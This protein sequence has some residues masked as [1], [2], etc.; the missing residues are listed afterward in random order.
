LLHSG[1]KPEE[2][3]KTIRAKANF[4]ADKHELLF[5]QF[6]INYNNEAEQFKKG[7]VLFKEFVERHEFDSGDSC[8]NQTEKCLHKQQQL[9]KPDENRKRK[10]VLCLHID[11]IGDKFWEEHC[12][13]LV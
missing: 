5:Q 1:L 9:T 8:E 4:S 10:K 11:I 13:L 6:G 3:E 12:N 7:T 2:A